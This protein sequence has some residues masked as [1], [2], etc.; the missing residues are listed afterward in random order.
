[1][2]DTIFA[3]VTS[4]GPSA[5][6]VFRISG[7]NSRSILKKLI[8]SRKLPTERKLVLKKIYYPRNK[9]E[10]FFSG[11]NSM[12]KF[13]AALNAALYPLSSPSKQIIKSS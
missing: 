6:S 9:K 4:I 11:F 7:S 12:I 2:Y 3:P 8:K 1:M 13:S 5:V 10:I